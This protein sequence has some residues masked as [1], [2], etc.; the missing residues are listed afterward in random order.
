MLND[1]IIEAA[2]YIA[3]KGCCSAGVI[4]RKF[5]IGYPEADLI[6]QELE[7]LKIV[8]GINDRGHREVLIA[9]DQ[10]EEYLARF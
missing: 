4:Q 3:D 6:M 2:Y 5:N 7:R 1:H 9:P 8:S 10:V